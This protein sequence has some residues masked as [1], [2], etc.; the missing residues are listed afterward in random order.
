MKTANQLADDH[1][2]PDD[3]D[4]IEFELNSEQVETLSR[5]ATIPQPGFDR[6]PPTEHSSLNKS[7]ER[8]PRRSPLL[9]GIAMASGFLSGLAYLALTRE[10]PAQVAQDVPS[11]SSAPQARSSAP[12]VQNE[13]VRFKNPFDAQE[14]FEFPPGT[15][16]AEARDAVAKLL[17]QRALDRRRPSAKAP[18]SGAK[19]AAH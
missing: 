16:D 13:P 17:L 3:H 10:P 7:A 1:L 6:I 2:V 19:Q 9:L 18:R 5:A 4:T 14:V 8:E 11:G 15:S 12:P